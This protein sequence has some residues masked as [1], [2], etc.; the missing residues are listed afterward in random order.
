M[1]AL[2]KRKQRMHRLDPLS[3]PITMFLVIY[4]Y[5][6][7]PRL[8]VFLFFSGAHPAQLIPIDHL[9]SLATVALYCSILWLPRHGNVSNASVH[10]PDWGK[11]RAEMGRHAE[12]CRPGSCGVMEGTQGISE[13]CKTRW[14]EIAARVWGF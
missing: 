8:V 1:S 10:P 7:C 3:D 4:I 2:R 11:S 14:S 5:A 9:H 6:T 12:F 13:V